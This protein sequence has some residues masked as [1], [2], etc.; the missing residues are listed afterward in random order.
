MD[1]TEVKQWNHIGSQENPVDIPSRGLRPQELLMSRLWWNGPAWL[2]SGEEDWI[3]NP[4]THAE[5]DLPEVREVKLVLSATNP[6][7]GL[8]RHYSEWNRMLRGV[9]WLTIYSKYLRKMING[10]QSLRIPDLN[11]VRKTILRMVQAECFSKEISSLERGQEVAKNSKLRS[12]NPFLRDG[13]ILVGGRLENSDMVD[14]HKHPVVLPA[15]HKVTRMIFEKYHLELLRGGPQLLL[16]E[17]RRLYWPLLGRVTAS[18]LRRVAAKKAWIAIFVCFSTK[19]VHLE[20]VQL[21]DDLSSRSFMPTLRCFMARREKCAKLYSDN[22]TNFV[23]AQKELVSMMKKASDYL[24]KEGIEWHFNPP[25]APHFGG[26][27]KSAVK[28]MKHHLKRVI[29]DH[30]LTS[31]EMRTLLCQIEAC[32]NS[33][34]M[35]P[36]NSDPSDLA[37]LTPS[38]FLIGGAMLLPDEQDI[39]KEDPKGLRRWQLVQ[40]L[41]QTFWKRWSKE[42]LPQIQIRGKWTSK[43]AQLAKGDVVIIKDDCMPPARWRLPH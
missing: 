25:S 29:S 39:T 21:A 22:G 1:V 26:I 41:M 7:N 24:E 33:R 28:S 27:W 35:T 8:L 18:G 23:G 12:L 40:N 37:V 19:A 3:L 16:S 32:L 20:Y 38:H 9:A 2:E 15:A 43:S 36:L 14:E 31:T 11:E 6:V 10:P 42:Y 34:P 5:E 17:V 4:I 30:K 13:L